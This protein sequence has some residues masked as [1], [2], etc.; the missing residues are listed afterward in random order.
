MTWELAQ[1]FFSAVA[2]LSFNLRLFSKSSEKNMAALFASAEIP[3]DASRYLS[4][5]FFISIF[6]AAAASAL[7]F[8][9]L[10]FDF[11][12][13]LATLLF[14]FASCML[15]FLF[16]PRAIAAK[17]EE[18][19]ESELPFLLREAAVYLDIGMPFEKCLEKIG[20]RGYALSPN[21]E[22]ACR[23]IKS[24]ATVQAALSGF[25][26]KTG[27]VA[28]KRCILILSSIYET[29]SGT[30]AV[31]RTA[32]ELSALQL[33]SMRMQSGR[34]SLFAIIFVAASALLPAFFAV[35]AAVSPLVSSSQISDIQI[36]LAF[37]VAFPLLNLLVLVAAFWVLPSSGQKQNQYPE[38]LEDFLCKR[39]FSHGTRAFVLLSS[40]VSLILAALFFFVGNLTLAA[41][42][43]CIAPTAYSAASYA[44]GRQIEDAEA[45]LPDALYSAASVHR[46]LS[47]EKTLTFL[48][49]GNFGR[50][51][52]AFEIAL[53]RQKAGETFQSSM[54]AALSHCP[55]Q[56]VERAFGLLT[57]AY[58]TG[59]NMRTALREAAQDVVSFFTLVRERAALLAIQRY[60]I[61]AAS[62]F[63]V[64][65]IIGTVVS[66]VPSLAAASSL[67]LGEQPSPPLS[68]TLIPACQIYLLIN[69]LLSSLLLAFSETN[70]KKAAL[71]FPV[72]A[73]LSQAA[74][75][76]A[77]SGGIALLSA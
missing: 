22:R 57:V 7:S 42:S 15:F 31:K 4:G 29:G 68:A 39:G 49:K 66:I 65:L 19:S 20:G 70:P 52:E 30:E 55:S 35:F 36:W 77:S 69:S 40:A 18:Q 37:I 53:R 63:L 33:S 8:A 13:S 71:Y 32:E 10:G 58:E 46:L 67:S 72:I 38:L 54:Q 24:G 11:F 5:S 1:R 51:S 2:S 14:A 75:A 41:L 27:S 16:L 73:P 74:F 44:A 25:S 64:P 34:L 61:L 12:D 47:S 56:L 28:V 21:F 48:A 60:T 3:E 26:S 43:I 17:K 23:E 50:L 62:A 45:R 59:A 76:F 9:A 6:L